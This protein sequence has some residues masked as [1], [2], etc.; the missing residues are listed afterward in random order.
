MLGIVGLRKLPAIKAGVQTSNAP[1]HISRDRMTPQQR[2]AYWAQAERGVNIPKVTSTSPQLS[3]SATTDPTF[4]GGAIVPPLLVIG[5]D[6]VSQPANVAN[7]P[8]MALATDLSYVIEGID[9]TIGSYRASTGAL[10]MVPTR[11]RASS[12]R[13][14]TRATRSVICR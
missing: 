7:P 11:R 6:F 14:S 9:A 5:G 13:S 2:A 10:R 3:S 1:G 4:L 8:D 12:S